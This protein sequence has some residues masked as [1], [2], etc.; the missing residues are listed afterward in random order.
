MKTK[1]TKIVSAA[2][3][4][5]VLFLNSCKKEETVIN[6]NTTTPVT[7]AQA[8]QT[9][10]RKQI[11]VNSTLLG[12]TGVISQLVSNSNVFFKNEELIG[13]LDCAIVVKDTTVFPHIA[14]F[15]FGP[16]GC[17]GSDGVHCS[18]SITME[19]T[20]ETLA[21]PGSQNVITFS[22]FLQDS[23]LL[24]GTLT[25]SNTGN[26]GSGNPT[27][28]IEFNV[29]TEFTTDRVSLNGNNTFYLEGV[30]GD[31]NDELDNVTYFTGGGT[32]NTVTETYTQ[33]VVTPLLIKDRPECIAHFVEGSILFQSATSP[34]RLID[35]GNGTCDDQATSTSSGLTENIT[36]D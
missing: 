7:K 35:Y 22:N 25:I 21:T 31:P 32:V 36:L 10:S 11:T 27:A 17:T 6:K 9:A 16:G 2:L 20:D 13:E 4:A 24:D 29:T 34:D 23:L 8:L 18:G 15:T 1:T 12:L 28:T 14:T 3:V 19:Y 5:S 33:T 26:N 30:L